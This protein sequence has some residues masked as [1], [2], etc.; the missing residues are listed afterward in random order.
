[1]GAITDAI[2]AVKERGDLDTRQKSA[3]FGKVRAD[4]HV[5]AIGAVQ[6]KDGSLVIDR[7]DGRVITARLVERGE[8]SIT[9]RIDWT[10]DGK[11]QS[12]SN[13]WVIVNPPCLVP[14]PSGDVVRESTDPETGEPTTRRYR[15]D[16][17]AALVA[18]INQRFRRPANDGVKARG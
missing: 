10:I 9:L 5:D 16:P 1:M 12:F 15:E 18:I 14:D 13:P 6:S 11:P 4:A 17:M 2:E 3:E 8:N 7:G